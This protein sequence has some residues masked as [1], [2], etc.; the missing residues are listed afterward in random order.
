MEYEVV[1][2]YHASDGKIYISKLYVQG[3]T[4][5]YIIQEIEQEMK[6][7]GWKV[8]DTE[9]RQLHQEGEKVLRKLAITS[10][11]LLGLGLFTVGVFATDLHLPHRGASS[12]SFQTEEDSG[13]LTDNVVWHFILNQVE[14]PEGVEVTLT[15]TFENAEEVT[16]IGT[17]VGNG[18]TYHF[19]IGRETH[20]ILENAF[21]NTEGGKL[22]LSHVSIK[23]IDPTPTEPTNPTQ[24]TETE[25][26][27]TEPKPTEPKPTEPTIKPTEVEPKPTETKTKPTETTP[28]MSTTPTIEPTIEPTQPTVPPTTPPGKLPQTGGVST[29]I[30]LLLGAA[31]IVYGMNLYNDKK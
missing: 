5:A 27:P 2:K 18:Q 31:M 20:E 15:A 9:I 1:N 14:V 21:T 22:L 8:E 16:V 3:D 29:S 26:K 12:E 25:P 10:G 11:F 17:P 23:P 28:T 13:G 4:K 30:L 24:P 6:A 7:Y 19:Y